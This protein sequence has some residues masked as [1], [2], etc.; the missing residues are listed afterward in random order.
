MKGKRGRPDQSDDIPM[1]GKENSA[2]K[3]REGEG[4]RY[5]IVFSLS[6]P[7][8]TTSFSSWAARGKKHF[9]FPNFLFSLRS[10]EHKFPMN[11]V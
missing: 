3:K 2:R 4:R 9:A 1:G 11:L 7:H 6:F 8:F 10:R 5:V